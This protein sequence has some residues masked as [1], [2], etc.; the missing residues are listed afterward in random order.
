ATDSAE[1]K[2]QSELFLPMDYVGGCPPEDYA[3][4][5]Q[6]WNTPLYDWKSQKE[7][8][9]DWWVKRVGF[10]LDVYDYLRIDHF[11]GFDSYFAI[12]AGQPAPK[13]HW[14]KGPGNDIID[15][16]VDKFGSD[17]IIAED[18][19]GENVKNVA[20]LVKHSGFAPTRVFQFAFYGKRGNVHLPYNLSENSIFYTGTHDNNTTLGWI[21]ELDRKNLKKMENYSGLPLW[22]V[23]D[24]K[25]SGFRW[26][27][28]GNKVT[29]PFQQGS[30]DFH[31]NDFNPRDK[32]EALKT[33]IKLVWSTNSRITI[34]P[35]Q[36]L[37]MQDEEFRINMPG[38]AEGNWE[39]RFSFRDLDKVDEEFFK[40]INAARKDRTIY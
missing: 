27:G 35:I 33:I 32:K 14:E 23:C 22:D 11:R 31:P 36:D 12:P 2:Y 4:D 28:S 29:A 6:V 15:I 38:T 1:G 19:G 25:K 17:R 13:G 21:G 16:F 3:K 26:P 40:G 34:I 9:Y 39:Y 7:N 10:C 30:I 37:L 20:K 5:G 8:G 18:L 24:I